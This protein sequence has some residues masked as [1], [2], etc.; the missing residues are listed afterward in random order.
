MLLILCIYNIWQL[1]LVYEYLKVT[2]LYMHTNTVI[3]K[4]SKIYH[5]DNIK[6]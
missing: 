4:S 1:V 6:F 5:I 2:P 3:V